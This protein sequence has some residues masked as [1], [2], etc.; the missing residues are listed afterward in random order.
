VITSGTT[1]LPEVGGDAALY[2]DPLSIDEIA[3]AMK[4]CLEDDDLRTA[5]RQRGLEQSALFSWDS[6]A[7]ATYDVYRTVVG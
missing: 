2:V 7:R 1:S 6:T 3:V 4:R 5:M